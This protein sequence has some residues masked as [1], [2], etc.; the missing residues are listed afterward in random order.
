MAHIDEFDLLNQQEKGKFK[1]TRKEKQH[2]K[3]V[4]INIKFTIKFDQGFDPKLL[5]DIPDENLKEE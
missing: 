4:H 1:K 3:E 2:E 5:K